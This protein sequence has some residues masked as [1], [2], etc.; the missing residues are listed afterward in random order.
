[1]VSNI[2]VVGVLSV[3]DFWLKKTLNWLTGFR[4]TGEQFQDAFFL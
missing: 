4:R 1:V 2:N 3:T